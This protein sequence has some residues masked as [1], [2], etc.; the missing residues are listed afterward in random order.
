MTLWWCVG[1]LGFQP[2]MLKLWERLNLD[3]GQVLY[4]GPIVLSNVGCKGTEDHLARCYH[5][6]INCAHYQDAGVRCG[7]KRGEVAVII[8]RRIEFAM[9][10]IRN[11]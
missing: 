4:R 2:L 9:I 7:G 5:G 6:G 11:L 8:N 3:E 1:S 10:M